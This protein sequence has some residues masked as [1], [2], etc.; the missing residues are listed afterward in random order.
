MPVFV[1]FLAIAGIVDAATLLR[2]T[3]YA[4][5]GVFV[6]AAVLTPPDWVSQI[7]LAVPMIGLYL[8]GVGVAF[9][10]GGGR[11]RSETSEVEERPV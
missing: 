4:I 9:I 5:M 2:G 1:F 7:F 8:L 11:K 3:P 6:L 10:F